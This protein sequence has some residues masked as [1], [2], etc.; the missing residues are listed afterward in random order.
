LRDGEFQMYRALQR[1]E[2]AERAGQAALCETMD[3]HGRQNKGDCDAPA[4]TGGPHSALDQSAHG[5]SGGKRSVS[6]LPT[7]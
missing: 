4:L 6:F 3:R 7:A 2:A 5:C 1:A